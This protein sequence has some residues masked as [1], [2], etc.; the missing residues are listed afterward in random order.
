MW[1]ERREQQK[2]IHAYTSSILHDMTARLFS[3]LEV[4]EKMS[5]VII[6]VLQ[7]RLFC[8][9]PKKTSFWYKSHLSKPCHWKWCTFP[10]KYSRY[11]QK[12]T[13]RSFRFLWLLRF[14]RSAKLSS[15]SRA[16]KAPFFPPSF[17][18]L[19]KRREDEEKLDWTALN[20]VNN[21]IDKNLFALD[22]VGKI[23]SSTPEGKAG[24][25]L[26]SL[27]ILSNL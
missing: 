16:R 10:L 21:V 23:S 22:V 19:H 18:I 17:I 7:K 1:L 25:S 24:E 3:P 27:G 5:C 12:T 11:C 15:R 2:K 14:A 26:Q 13:E 9:F 4:S 8:F 20:S 6:F